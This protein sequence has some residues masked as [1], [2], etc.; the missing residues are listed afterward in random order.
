MV[1]IS[2]NKKG[3]DWN[4]FAKLSESKSDAHTLKRPLC[5][6]KFETEERSSGTIGSKSYRG[7]RSAPTVKC[8][9]FP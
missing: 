7:R 9:L 3:V 2:L 1:I 6:F 4:E 5:F 8:P